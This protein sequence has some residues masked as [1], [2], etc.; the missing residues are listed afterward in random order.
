M[1]KSYLGNSD[2]F[3]FLH[4]PKNL[5]LSIKKVN[6]SF[7]LI[8]HLTG[9]NMLDKNI[10]IATFFSVSVSIMKMRSVFIEKSLDKSLIQ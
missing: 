3:L 5:I 6:R 7:Y 2:P 4:Q 9:M 8:Q 1:H 10:L